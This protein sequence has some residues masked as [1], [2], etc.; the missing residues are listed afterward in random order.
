MSPNGYIAEM[1]F[2][3]IEL[4]LIGQ[5]LSPNTLRNF[6]HLMYHAKIIDVIV[7]ITIFLFNSD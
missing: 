2:S 5:V 3:F 6:S 1:H 4:I 7:G